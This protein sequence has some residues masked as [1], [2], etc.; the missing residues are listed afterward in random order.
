MKSLLILKPWRCLAV[1]LSSMLATLALAGPNRGPDS[2]P[3]PQ[4]KL[5]GPARG[6]AAVDAL[7][8]DLPGVARAYG[9]EPHALRVKLLSDHHLQSDAGGRLLYTEPVPAPI[10]SASQTIQ[11]LAPLAETFQLHSRPGAKRIIYL[12]FNGHTLVN[13]AWNAYTG[14]GVINAPAWSLDA[15]LT[16]FNADERTRIQYIWERVAEDYAPFDVDVTTELTSEDQITRT[17]YNDEYYGTRA[18]VSPIS[19]YFGQYGGIAYV[20]V[21]D[22][23]GDYYKPALVFPENLGPNGESY[24]AE[25]ISHEVGHNL[26][27]SHDGTATGCGTTGTSPCGYYSGQGNWA[28]IMG[29]GYY[30]STVQFSRGEYANAN[31]SEDDLTMIA[32]YLGYRPDDHGDSAGTATY[33]QTGIVLEAAGVIASETDVDVFAFSTGDGPVTINLNPAPRS[34]NLN[35]LAVLRDATGALVATS[36]PQGALNASFNLNLAAGTYFLYVQGTGEGDPAV[37]GYSAYGSIGQ[38]SIS[39]TCIATTELPPLAFATATPAV[40]QPNQNVTFSGAG[41]FDP[42]GGALVD[43]SWAFSDAS[44]GSGSSLVKS[45]PIAGSYT[46]TLTVTDDESNQSSTTVS[47]TVNAPPVAAISVSPGTSGN[48]PMAVTF[49]G[50][51]SSDAEGPIASYSWS[52]GDGSSGTGATVSKTYTVAGTYTAIL[53]VTDGNGATDTESVVL[54]V[55]PDG[56]RFIRVDSIALVGQNSSGTRKVTATVKVTN[57]NGAVVSGVK[58]AGTWSGMVTGS[59]TA[60]TSTLGTAVLTSKNFRKSGTVTFRITGLTRSGYTYTAANNNETSESI[61]VP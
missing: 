61:L 55:S 9:W 14:V 46:A 49:S 26:N 31:N 33:F 29:V 56:T 37:T 48:A 16:T 6:Q 40:V 51:D 38:Y 1:A 19:S 36:N 15:D 22:Y 59:S 17:D 52:F 28:P 54:N 44:T 13:G 21:Y 34:A 7:A 4:V 39:G 45:F 47:V 10:A 8:A 11:P 27:L 18:L 12:D 5:R 24:I 23:A 60:T 20:G 53:T 25:A 50:T 42:D 57:L 2:R 30:V 3:F 43:Y 41:S 35:I 32:G 58:V